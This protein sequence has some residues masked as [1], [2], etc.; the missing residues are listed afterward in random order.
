MERIQ[1]IE[2]DSRARLELSDH[3]DERAATVV[4]MLFGT[5]PDPPADRVTTTAR[6]RSR[7]RARTS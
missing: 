1:Q 6:G 5:P 3:A 2:V 7:G 4:L